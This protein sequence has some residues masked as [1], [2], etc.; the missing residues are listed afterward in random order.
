MTESYTGYHGTSCENGA[1]ISKY[2]SYHYSTMNEKC[3][4]Y[5]GDGVY[6]FLDHKEHA[7]SW[8]AEFREYESWMIF[9]SSI[10]AG[11]CFDLN[12]RSTRLL[13]DEIYEKI[14][15]RKSFLENFDTNLSKIKLDDLEYLD[16]FICNVLYLLDKSYDVFLVRIPDKHTTK[17]RLFSRAIVTILCVKNQECIMTIEEVQRSA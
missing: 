3:R 5:L 13:F 2:N 8:C 12:D 4:L 14:K 11:L 6:F 7:I 1:L 10:E 15:E 16:G 17:K 9:K